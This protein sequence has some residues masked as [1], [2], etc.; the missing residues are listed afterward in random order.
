[1]LTQCAPSPYNYLAY[2]VCSLTILPY[3]TTLSPLTMLPHYTHSSYNSFA[4]HYAPLLYSL[5]IQ[6]FH[7][8]LCSL[9]ILTHHTTLSPLTMLPHY[10]LLPYITLAYSYAHSLCSLTIQ[11]F[12]LSSMLSQKAPLSYNSFASHNAPSLYSLT[13]LPHYA[14]SPYISFAR[15]MASAILFFLVGRLLTLFVYWSVRVYD[16][17]SFSKL[18]R[19]RARG[20]NELC[21]DNY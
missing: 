17:L 3:H 20:M 15:N 21:R 10:A 13:M 12:S 14:P 2:Q 16:V 9:T 6:F 1:M 5:I 4:S 18:E 19:V 7:L 8:S 11:L